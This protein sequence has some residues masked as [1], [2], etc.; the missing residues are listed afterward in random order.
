[1]YIITWENAQDIILSLEDKIMFNIRV[2]VYIWRE[3]FAQT[4]ELK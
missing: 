2:K 1:M 3:K 4:K